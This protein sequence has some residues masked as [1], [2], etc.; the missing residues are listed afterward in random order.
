MMFAK[1][2]SISEHDIEEWASNVARPAG[3]KQTRKKPTPDDV[4]ALV[5]EIG[6]ILKKTVI[7]ID[8][9]AKGI[10]K[11]QAR[12]LVDQLIDDEKLFEHFKENHDSRRGR[13]PVFLGKYR[14][15]PISSSSEDADNKPDAKAD[16]LDLI[17]KTGTIEE[18]AIFSK[19]SQLEPPIN[20][21][22]ARGYLAE[23]RHEG[24]ISESDKGT[25]KR[26][27][28]HWSRS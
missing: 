13:N 4:L 6:L 24:V 15:I 7:E 12:A 8:A 28:I 3:A 11:H 14:P 19:A 26:P 23:L 10:S 22:D 25:K 16:I 1:D 17:P 27:Q 5:P 9:P 20:K 18:L 21:S 2:D